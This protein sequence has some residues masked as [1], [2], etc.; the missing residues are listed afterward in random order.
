MRIPRSSTRPRRPSLLSPRAPAGS[1][2]AVWAWP[3]RDIVNVK[4]LRCL[5]HCFLLRWF[6]SQLSAC[7]L[8][9]F[10]TIFARAPNSLK[11][12]P[13]A[14]DKTS[15][16]RRRATLGSAIVAASLRWRRPDTTQ[17]PQKIR[18]ATQAYAGAL[19]CRVSM[20]VRSISVISPRC[21]LCKI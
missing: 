14:V 16:C 13:K 19:R 4:P 10:R 15:S 2:P 3:T 8:P 11:L 1:S 18:K 9:S 21:I 20:P 7:M 6:T 17:R 12:K 5:V